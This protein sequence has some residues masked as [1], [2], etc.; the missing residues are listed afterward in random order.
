MPG[1]T[2]RMIL[3][4]E[5]VWPTITSCTCTQ[6]SLNPWWHGSQANHLEKPQKTAIQARSPHFYKLAKVGEVKDLTPE[7]PHVCTHFAVL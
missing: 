7:H 3:T 6:L 2:E 1:Q 4:L 5:Q